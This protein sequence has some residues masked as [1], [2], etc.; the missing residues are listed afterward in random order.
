LGAYFWPDL[1][2]R[3]PNETL[4]YYLATLDEEEPLYAGRYGKEEGATKQKFHRE[5]EKSVD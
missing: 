2:G 5:G 1:N 4:F 3:F